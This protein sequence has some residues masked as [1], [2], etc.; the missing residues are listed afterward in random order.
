[1]LVWSLV[2]TPFELWHQEGG[3]VSVSASSKVNL[4]SLL[5]NPQASTLN[6]GL[7]PRSVTIEL[8]LPFTMSSM[9]LNFFSTYLVLVEL[10]V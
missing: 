6:I 7:G 9:N 3:L 4:L 8:M 1:M 2:G 10:T 5:T